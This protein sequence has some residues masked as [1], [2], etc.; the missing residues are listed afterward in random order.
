MLVGFG[1]KLGL[2]R[3]DAEEAAQRTVVA[4]CQAYGKGQYD[5]QKGRFKNWLLGIAH[6]EIADL[7]KEKARQPLFG[8]QPSSIGDAFQ[9]ISDPGSLSEIWE[10]EWRAY[11]VRCCFDMAKQRFTSRDVQIFQMLTTGQRPISQVAEEMQ[12]S[13]TAVRHV[14]HRVLTFMREEESRIETGA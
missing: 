3:H 6:H 9:A 13:Y 2:D 5:P 1:R 12:M 7:C 4:F 11:V 10:Q 14:K 8:N